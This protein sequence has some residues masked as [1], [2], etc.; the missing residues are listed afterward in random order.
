[1]PEDN[2]V[3]ERRATCEGRWRL[4]IRQGR[5]HPPPPTLRSVDLKRQGIAWKAGLKLQTRR[6]AVIGADLLNAWSS[7]TELQYPTIYRKQ[8]TMAA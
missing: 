6:L 1:M 2:W 7:R 4:A 3:Q 5:L 8:R